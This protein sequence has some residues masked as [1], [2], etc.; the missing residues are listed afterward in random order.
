MYAASWVV[1]PLKYL[2]SLLKLPDRIAFSTESLIK[3]Q[4]DCCQPSYQSL[5]GTKNSLSII[6]PQALKPI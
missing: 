3:C 4:S 6:G 1:T 2:R 5:L